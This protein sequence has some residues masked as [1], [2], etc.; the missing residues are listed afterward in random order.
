MIVRSMSEVTPVEW[1]NGVSY[2]FLVDGD[3]M[4]Y[5]LTDTRVRAG[6][7]SALQY[8]KHLE[9][10]YCISGRGEVIDAEGRSHPIVPGTMYALNQ[11]DAHYLCAADGE[12][13]RL[14]CVFAPALRGDE[15]H[16]LS[17]HEFSHY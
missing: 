7:R 4:G 12:D 10:C 5:T 3:R 11:H 9:S 2:R 13:L 16:S 14:I 6:T 1:G 8:R 17:E 15:R